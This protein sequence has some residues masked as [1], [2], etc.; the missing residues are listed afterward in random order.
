MAASAVSSLFCD[1]SIR[2]LL[3]CRVQE[4]VLHTIVTFHMD[5]DEVYTHRLST[6]FT[7]M[8]VECYAWCGQELDQRLRVDASSAR[9]EILQMCEGMHCIRLPTSTNAEVTQQYP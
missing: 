5:F 2:S 1:C 7:F 9:Q 4:W 8:S 6:L 3:L